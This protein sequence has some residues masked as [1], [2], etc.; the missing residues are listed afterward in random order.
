M[1]GGCGVPAVLVG[2][3]GAEDPAG[4]FGFTPGGDP[5]GVDAVPPDDLAECLRRNGFRVFLDGD[6][7]GDEVEADLLRCE[8]FARVNRCTWVSW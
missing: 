5:A 6:G 8:H 3:G 2:V 1:S 4:G 7:A